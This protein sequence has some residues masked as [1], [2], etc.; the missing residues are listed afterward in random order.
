MTHLDGFYFM[1][2][3]LNIFALVW[4]VVF[5]FL[6]VCLF[7]YFFVDFVLFFSFACACVFILNHSVVKGHHIETNNIPPLTTTYQYPSSK[8]TTDGK[9][10]VLNIHASIKLSLF[11]FLS[12][13]LYGKNKN[14]LDISN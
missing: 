3:F 11:C 12:F 1:Y 7:F 14:S 10:F 13:M 6:F 5:S 4:C 8:Q 2:T 9:H